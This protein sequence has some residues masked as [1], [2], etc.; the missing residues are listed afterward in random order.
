MGMNGL[1][2][3][4]EVGEGWSMGSRRHFSM[5]GY[6][7]MGWMMLVRVLVEFKI[8]ALESWDVSSDG[9]KRR[10]RGA[11]RSNFVLLYPLISREVGLNWRLEC[12]RVKMHLPLRQLRMNVLIIEHDAVPR[13]AP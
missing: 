13:Y 2:I 1:T 8:G 9:M 10:Q 5:S 12:E 4:P 11:T 6:V 3:A 7:E